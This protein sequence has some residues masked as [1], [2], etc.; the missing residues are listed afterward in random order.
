MTFEADL[1]EN[2]QNII[3]DIYNEMVKGNK[4]DN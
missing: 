1:P 4:N 3:K 2:Y